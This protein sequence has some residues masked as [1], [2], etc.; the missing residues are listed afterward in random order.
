MDG[1]IQEE[2][3][4]FIEENNVYGFFEDAITLKSGRKSHFYANWRNVVEDV[5]L[6]D[7]LAEYVISFTESHGLEVDTFYGVPEGATKLG[8]ITQFKHA[9]QFENYTKGSHILAMGRAKPKDHGAPKDK[10]FVGMP[11]G[12]TV[13]IEDVTTTGGS[14]LKTLNGLAESGVHVVGVISLTNRMEKRDDGLSVKEAVENKGFSFHSMSSSLDLLPIMYKKLQPG[15][16][17]AEAIEQ[18]FKE[19]GVRELSL[20]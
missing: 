10:Y 7:R 16:Y 18:E 12:N 8:V 15:E 11:Q 20:R 1:F 3:N 17:I 4:R 14:L 5:W 19:F 13:V 9:Q 6:T 2:F